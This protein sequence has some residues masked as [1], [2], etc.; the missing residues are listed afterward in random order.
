MLAS[1][2]LVKMVGFQCM[3]IPFPRRG[4]WR[5]M[6]WRAFGWIFFNAFI[7]CTFMRSYNH[8]MFSTSCYHA[9]SV[10]CFLFRSNCA[11][12]FF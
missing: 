6:S 3:F 1:W 4:K 12:P 11:S 2:D 8:L 9:Y 5:D 10:F 7:G